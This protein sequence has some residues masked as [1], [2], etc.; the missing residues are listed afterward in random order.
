MFVF[1]HRIELQFSQ[2]MSS[3]GSTPLSYSIPPQF[4]TMINTLVY[5]SS[6]VREGEGLCGHVTLTQCHV[7]CACV[8]QVMQVCASQR[9]QLQAEADNVRIVIMSH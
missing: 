7:T 1:A 6:Q 3:K 9:V 5:L 2:L 4:F 8:G